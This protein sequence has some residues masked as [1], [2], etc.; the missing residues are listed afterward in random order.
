MKLF[1]MVMAGWFLFA[2][3]IAAVYE[4]LAVLTGAPTISYLLQVWGPAN[5]QLSMLF[6]FLGG[7][8]LGHWTS[9]AEE[10]L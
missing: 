9:P 7:W 3:T 5:Y 10:R 2:L 1:A 4:V 8:L 6:A